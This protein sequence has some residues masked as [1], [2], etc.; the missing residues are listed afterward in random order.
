MLSRTA[1][2]MAM[3]IR[4]HDWSDAPYRVDRA[5]HRRDLDSNSVHTELLTEREAKDILTN[6]MFVSAQALGSDDP[7]FDPMEYAKACGVPKYYL[8]GYV[9]SGIRR[10]EAGMI[11][12]PET[13]GGGKRVAED[14]RLR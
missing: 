2:L 11:E 3:E 4:N 5:G 13:W 6:V 12:S 14:P 8:N 9:D 7:N 1:E 10:D